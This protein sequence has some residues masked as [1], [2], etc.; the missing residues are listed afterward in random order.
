MIV[1][2]LSSVFIEKHVVTFETAVLT[3]LMDVHEHG[4]LH[5]G[6]KR[7]NLELT[8]AR[9]PDLPQPHIKNQVILI[10]RRYHTILFGDVIVVRWPMHLEHGRPSVPGTVKMIGTGRLSDYADIVELT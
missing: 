7:W 6:L 9:M 10:E 1:A 8:H 5:F 2:E 4:E 3:L